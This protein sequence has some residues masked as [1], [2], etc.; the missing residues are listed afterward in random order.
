MPDLSVCE[1]KKTTSLLFAVVALC[2]GLSL[3]IQRG[4]GNVTGCAS[5]LWYGT[6]I[7]MLW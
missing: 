5:R 3:V 2:V 4:R 7:A 1:K 6:Y